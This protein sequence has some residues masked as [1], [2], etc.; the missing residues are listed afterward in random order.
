[1]TIT[2]LSACGT[3]GSSSPDATTTRQLGVSVDNNWGGFSW[4]L[5]KGV[6]Q[7]A[8]D[9]VPIPYPAKGFLP[10]NPSSYVD[11]VAAGVTAGANQIRN[12]TGQFVLVG[13]SQGAE[14]IS[15]LLQ[16][17]QS[18]SLTAHM[19]QLVA[20]VTFGNPMREQGH[21]W[22]G[23]PTGCTGQGINSDGLL[24]NTPRTWW[25]MTN[26]FDLSGNIPTG[27]AGAIITAIWNTM[28]L[29]DLTSLPQVGNAINA[30]RG[31]GLATN[32]LAVAEAARFLL[33]AGT[34]VFTKGH[35]CF[36]TATVGST[37]LTFV[38]TAVNY[39]NSHA[40]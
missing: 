7:S 3:G 11:S 16:E 5:A 27:E 40:Q 28:G 31:Q 33:N 36:G 1:L 12:L 9:A 23:D 6:N 8:F 22:P 24:G 13:Y 17:L 35:A 29:V 39:L 18:G 32:P 30:V 19:P 25:D 38:Q 34:Q 26:T 2:I 20:G 14:V 15:K 4:A 21:T 10:S 37:G